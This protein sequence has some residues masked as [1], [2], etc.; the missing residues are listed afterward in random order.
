MPF[1]FIHLSDIHFGQEKRQGELITQNDVKEQLLADA[2][3]MVK[4]HAD[5]HAC[6]II[7]TGDI[8]YGGKRE[9]YQ[10]AAEWLDRLADAIGCDQTA[11]HVVP[12]NHDIDRDLISSGCQ[13]MINDVLEN[14]EARLDAYLGTEKDREL[15]FERFTHYRPFA[16]GYDCPLDHDGG[17]ASDKSLELAPGRQLRFIGLNSALV[18]SIGANEEGRLLLGERQRV[19]PRDPGVEVVV[20]GHHPLHWLRDS[21]TARRY[22]R[23]RARVFVSGHEHNPS[24]RVDEIG[25]NEH[26]LV[27]A[28][29]ATVPPHVSDKYTYT[30]NLLTF[31]WDA[32][33]D[34]LS[35]KIFPRAWSDE[36]TRFEDDPARLGGHQPAHVLGCPNFRDAPSTEEGKPETGTSSS[37]AM[38]PIQQ[39]APAAESGV[40]PALEGAEQMADRFPILL[41]RFFR[42]LAPVQRLAILVDLKELP[43]DMDDKLTHMME[44]QAI[45]RIAAKGKLDALEAAIDAAESAAASRTETMGE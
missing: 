40:T 39:S 32:A 30:Y 36:R 14:G 38:D 34:G 41:L 16:E 11:V 28:A 2:K 37:E 8:A 43:D 9:E 29:G 31:D 6:G 1:T 24:L 25:E 12:G 26:L 35:V 42:D 22:V 21:A 20:L 44:R 27:L 13:L 23:S 5:G 33:S 45:D 3:R 17:Y 18:C 4:D 19:L 15:L 10:R 7:V